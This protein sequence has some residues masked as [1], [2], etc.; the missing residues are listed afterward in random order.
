MKRDGAIKSLDPDSRIID[1]MKVNGFEL[2][3]QDL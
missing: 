1:I 3:Y 2:W